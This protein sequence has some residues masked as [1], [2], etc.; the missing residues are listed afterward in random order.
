V[1]MLRPITEATGAWE[2]ATDWALA[3][4]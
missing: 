4:A 3:S 2:Q 1:V